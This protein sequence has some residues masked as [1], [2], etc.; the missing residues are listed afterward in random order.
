MINNI[1]DKHN[2]VL[3][4]S[5][6]FGNVHK[7]SDWDYAVSCECYKEIRDKLESMGVPLLRM[8]SGEHRLHNLHN[9]KFI[10][11]GKDYNIIVFHSDFLSRISTLN[12]M[13]ISLLDNRL[14][15]KNDK[16]RRHRFFEH[17]LDFLYADYARICFQTTL[18]DDEI[19]F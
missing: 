17:L 10:Y 15:N 12:S 16:E 11:R 9:C 1:L 6:I 4:G 14:L 7:G 8:G 2:S 13:M 5:R 19:Q 3:T 18:N